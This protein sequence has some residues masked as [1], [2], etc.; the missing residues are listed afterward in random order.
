MPEP[1]TNQ[2]TWYALPIEEVAKQLQVDPAKG[3]SASEAA[4]R[5]QQYGSNQLA[6]KKKESGLQ[7]FLRQYKDFMQILL[8]GAAIVN[9]IFTQELG[10]TLVLIGL[11][12]FNAVLGRSQESK[13]EASLASLEKMMKNIAR[14]R[15]DGQAIEIEA[16]QLVPGD[17]VL[18]EAGNRVP[19]DGRLFVTAT[20]EIE[21]AALTGESVAS[22]KDSETIDKGEVPLGDRHCMAY[23]NT[24]VTRGRGEMIVTTT[25]MGTEMGHIADLLN[26]TEAD[27][28]PLQKQLDRLVIIIAG[29]AGIAFILM[30]I[31][32]LRQGQEFD[33]I[34]LAG[35]ALAISAIPTGMPA[36]I[37]T[38]Y[39]MGTRVLAEQ[40]AI[41]KRLP[42]VETLGSVSAI[43]SDKTGTLT[44][45]KMTAVEFSLPGQNR[46][47]VTGE[48]YSTQGQLLHAGGAKLDLDAVMLP[49]ALCADARLDGESLIGDPTEGALIVLA[50]KG[51]ISVEAAR[52][53]YPRVA[54]VPF[55]SDYKFMA[56]FHN[57]T[58]AQGK[59]VVRAFV[60]GAPDVLIAR[61]GFFW[62]PEGPGGQLT[63]EYRGLALKENERMAAA[64][65][66]VMVV[67]RRDFDPA[68]FDPKGKLLDLMKDLTLLAMVGIVDPPRAEARD[69][70]AKCHSAG[71]QVR[72]ITGDHA[73]TAAAI[74]HQLGIEG[75]ALTGAQFKAK[76][77]EELMNE[78]PEIGVI[79]RVAPED[80]IRLVDLLQRK[81]N[82]VAMTGDGVND[83]PALKKADI[84]VAMGITGT[85]VSKGAAVMILTDDNFATI[86]KAVEYGRA[87]YDNLSKYVRFQITALVAFITSYLGA[88]LFFILGGV[89]FSPLVVLWINF[90]VQVPIAIALGFDK[91]LPGLMDR[92]PRP[93]SQPVLSRAQWVRLIFI[94]LVMAVVTLAVETLYDTTDRALAVTMGFVVFSL[95]NI[96]VGLNNRSE[97]G[98]LFQMSTVTDRRQLGLYG[99]ALL[100]TFLPTELGVTQ[101][102]LGLTSLD[103]NQWLIGIG[104]AIALVLIS[105]VMKFFLRRGRKHDDAAPAAAAPAQA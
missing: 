3:L 84:G 64:G 39:S 10:T 6:S 46:Y 2:P 54:E 31:L 61:S 52:Q 104:L 67:A 55:D 77:D 81:Q 66:R 82:V 59:P 9:Q 79:A 17:I 19:A 93:L 13:A 22:S 32:G 50:E 99:L 63:D 60:K 45:N 100:F 25:G 69:A 101:R 37:T 72:M 74:G 26:K 75:T 43:C 8:L 98:T 12:V 35:I 83:A 87:I 89:P 71:I 85:E 70:I 96:V 15:R 21:E 24:A 18:M 73:V 91:P 28:T 103:L 30:I 58:D 49:M 56:T 16:E 20:L 14:V 105:E 48:G 33:A 65:E 68:T 94:G 5:L 40:N 62:M 92:K 53:Q 78:L 57:M 95:F 23:M 42:S 102:I 4:Q 76:S 34:F 51:G 38:L 97:S 27:K 90:L 41:V 29:I 47:K 7:A 36:V 44:L 11:T 86:V 1:T 80:K 88:A